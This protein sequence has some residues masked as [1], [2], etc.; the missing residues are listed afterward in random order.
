MQ[1]ARLNCKWR[2]HISETLISDPPC[3]VNVGV[4]TPRTKKRYKPFVRMDGPISEFPGAF[5]SVHYRRSTF[6]VTSNRSMTTLDCHA[7]L[8]SKKPILHRHVSCPEGMCVLME[9]KEEICR[10]H[11]LSLRARASLSLTRTYSVLT[12]ALDL[13]VGVCVPVRIVIRITRAVVVKVSV[14]EKCVP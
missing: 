14:L 9:T 10:A 12:A 7:K 3:N 11:G 2:V 6:T 5:S 4:S 13:H 8:K 1:E